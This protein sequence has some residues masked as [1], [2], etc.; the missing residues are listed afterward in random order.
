MAQAE[1]KLVAVMAA[2]VADYSR[3][4]TADEEGTH[5][6]LGRL[7]REIIQPLVA[8]HDGEVFKTTGDGFLAE[9]PSS[10]QAVC[11]GIELQKKIEADRSTGVS[12]RMGI[13]AGP[14]LVDEGDVFGR[15]VI[16]AARL[17]RMADPGGICVS[18]VVYDQIRGCSNLVAEDRGEQVLKNIPGTIRAW[19]ITG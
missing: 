9:F 1:R 4:M 12:F 5:T 11:C 13:N 14:V 6:R 19:A 15:T 10:V 18:Q 17:E 2:D 3:L 8:R 16:V 7:L